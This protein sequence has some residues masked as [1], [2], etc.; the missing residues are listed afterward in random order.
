MQARN[1]Y[2]SANTGLSR[3]A[4]TNTWLHYPQYPRDLRIGHC[5]CRN[6]AFQVS[7]LHAWYP[8]FKTMGTKIVRTDEIN[9]P[10]DPNVN[11]TG[12]KYN[13]HP[14][15]D[16]GVQRLQFSESPVLPTSDILRH[17]WKRLCK[18]CTCVVLY[19]AQPYGCPE[20]TL[21]KGIFS[22]A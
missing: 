6:F 19:S 4:T 22:N 16:Y 21:R 11:V 1:A 2:P 20:F 9:L 15:H 5:R 10:Y 17:H 12:V 8:L 13:P 14:V 7:D 3:R 18:Y